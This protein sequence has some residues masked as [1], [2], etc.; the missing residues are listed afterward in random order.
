MMIG[1]LLISFCPFLLFYVEQYTLFLLVWIPFGIAIAFM[2]GG[3]QTLIS[4]IEHKTNQILTPLYQSA[5]NIGSIAGGALAGILI[6]LEFKPKYIFFALGILVIF[7]MVLIYKLGLSKEDEFK[8]EKTPFKPPSYDHL[9]LGIMLMVYFG[10]LGIIID[11][12]ALWITKD[13]LAPPFLGGLVIIFFNIPIYEMDIAFF[14]LSYY[15][16][17]ICW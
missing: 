3:A 10:S 16:N 4:L 1:Y 11:W 6:R 12:S 15:K 5:F 9:K 7:N 13:L 14:F 8:Y 2:M 17:F